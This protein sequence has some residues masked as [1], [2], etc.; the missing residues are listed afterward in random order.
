MLLKK[1]SFNNF[2][3]DKN[4]IEAVSSNMML[5][6]SNNLFIRKTIKEF[7]DYS[8]LFRIVENNGSYKVQRYCE[9]QITGECIDINELDEFVSLHKVLNDSEYVGFSARQWTYDVTVLYSGKIFNSDSYF[10]LY[11][12]ENDTLE[13]YVT[14]EPYFAN[15]FFQNISN[16]QKS[17]PYIIVNSNIK[18]LKSDDNCSDKTF[19]IDIIEEQIKEK[20]NQKDESVKSYSKGKKSS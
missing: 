6:N 17:K 1:I 13:F 3:K 4:I 5:L 16:I 11:I 19:I 7:D 20:Y 18:Y 9:D 10:T 8:T 2:L 14:N 12:G 15:G